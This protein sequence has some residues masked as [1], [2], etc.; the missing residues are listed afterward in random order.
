MGAPKLFERV[1][2]CTP[3]TR[4]ATKTVSR[5]LSFFG[6]LL[7]AIPGLGIPLPHSE[8]YLL[9]CLFRHRSMVARAGLKPAW[10][11]TGSRE[12]LRLYSAISQYCRSFPAVIALSTECIH[13]SP[14]L[15]RNI[16]WPTSLQTRRL[17]LCRLIY[18][19][20]DLGRFALV[21]TYA[22]YVPDGGRMHRRARKGKGW[23]N[24][25]GY[26]FPS[27]IFS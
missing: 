2:I 16:W 22:A 7:L 24:G 12:L 21:R 3:H 13:G 5:A 4:T 11:F 1:K 18:L 15:H 17:P 10:I 23:K 9:V 25:S 14:E 26:I 6:R 20:G 8:P 27:P 19:K